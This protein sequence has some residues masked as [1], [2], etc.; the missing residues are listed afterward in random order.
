MLERDNREMRIAKLVRKSIAVRKTANQE[1]CR[2]LSQAEQALSC[3]RGMEDGRYQT[4]L[5][6]I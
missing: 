5:R 1:L 6:Y 4:Y 2:Y 3:K